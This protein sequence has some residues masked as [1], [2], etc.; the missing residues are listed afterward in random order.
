MFAVYYFS[1]T[2]KRNTRMEKRDQIHSSIIETKIDYFKLDQ[3]VPNRSHKTPS[4]LGQTRPYDHTWSTMVLNFGTL[5][6]MSND[7]N[8]HCQIHRRCGNCFFLV[9]KFECIALYHSV[10]S[11]F[12]Q[13][14]KIGNTPFLT[15]QLIF[16]QN[17]SLSPH[18][19]EIR[20]SG[21]Y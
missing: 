11:K 7:K 14:L 16:P 13:G 20:Q 5:W 8:D 9:V 12:T 15:D 17:C 21:R 3:L 4:R 18:E 10:D 6:K 19:V 2:C 1:Y